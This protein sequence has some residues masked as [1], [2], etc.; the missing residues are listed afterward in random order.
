M[1]VH[2]PVGLLS[3]AIAIFIASQIGAAT[4]AKTT[5]NWQLDNLEKQS[6][7]LKDAKKKFAEAVGQRDE[8]VKKVDALQQKYTALL[9]D[10][11]DLAATDPDAAKVVEKYKIQRQ[12][13]ADAPAADAP[14]PEETKPDGK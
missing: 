5:M 11:L 9:T 12:A 4:R 13:P 8:V 6:A 1:S 10:V 2:L 3:L 7:Q 14:K